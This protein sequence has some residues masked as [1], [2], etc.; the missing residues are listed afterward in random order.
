MKRIKKIIA[1]SVIL[2]IS[3][4]LC[5]CSTNKIETNVNQNSNN[6][7]ENEDCQNYISEMSSF[8]KVEDGYYFTSDSKLLYFD[9][10]N[11]QAYP[12]CSKT[13]CDHSNSNCQA[14]LSPLKF[15][16]EM[17][18]YYYDNALYLLG[19]ENKGA[20]SESVYIYQI[21]LENFKQKKAAYLFDSTS[22]ISVVCTIHR[23]YV[24][25]TY[26]GGEMEETKATLYRTKLGE[27]SQNSQEKVFE[28]DG[29]GATIARLSAYGNKLFFNTSSYSDLQGNGYETVLNC[30]DI[31]TLENETIPQ[32]KYSHFA[33]NGKVYYCKDENTIAYYDIS[34]KEHKAFCK[35]D[36]PCYISADDNYIYF[37]N[38]QSII[39]GKT[40]KHNRAILVYDKSGNYITNIIP[41]SSE[42][43]CYFGGN[44]II[45]FKETVYEEATEA[46]DAKGYYVVDKSQLTSS[47]KQFI[48]ME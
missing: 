33:D 13:N 2:V 12:V 38:L 42:D 27:L 10:E 19:R 28:F 16:P 45:I 6:Y 48:D 23:G 8:V 30:M 26:D 44:D 9:T 17:S 11:Y 7:I 41:K 32:R 15:Y 24:Y 37:D 5:S 29:I 20:S 22:G 3:A 47:D 46:D 31:H 25:F 40:E 4:S 18:M 34:S 1:L 14:Y 35:I 39:V 21:S 36:G 43:E